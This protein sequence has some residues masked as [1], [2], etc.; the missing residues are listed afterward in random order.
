MVSLKIAS[1]RERGALSPIGVQ[2]ASPLRRQHLAAVIEAPR[3]E[4]VPPDVS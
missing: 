4:N 3:P 2:H 1:R